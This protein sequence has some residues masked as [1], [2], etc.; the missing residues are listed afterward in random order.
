MLF[1]QLVRFMPRRL[2]QFVTLI[3]EAIEESHALRAQMTQKHR[4]GFDS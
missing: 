2:A 1:L 3:A 4:L